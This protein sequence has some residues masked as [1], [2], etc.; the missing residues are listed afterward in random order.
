MSTS[1]YF[2]LSLKIPCAGRK[3]MH[4]LGDESVQYNHFKLAL[5]ANYWATF[6]FVIC[7]FLSSKIRPLDNSPLSTNVCRI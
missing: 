7:P 1:R 6:S 5:M 2:T 4:L 3:V